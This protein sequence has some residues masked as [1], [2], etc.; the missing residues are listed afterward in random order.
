MT[1][2]VNYQDIATPDKTVDFAM[3][4]RYGSRIKA[5]PGKVK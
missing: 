1:V 5:V 2:I 4:D 3:Q